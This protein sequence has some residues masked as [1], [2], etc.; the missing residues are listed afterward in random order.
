VRWPVTNVGDQAIRIVNAMQPHGQFRSAEMNIG[1]DL[2]VG[3]A[4]ELAL[5]VAFTASPG[6]LV[7]NP[8]LILLLREQD[9]EWRLLSRVRVRAGQRGEPIADGQ[10][11]STT[12]RVGA[13]E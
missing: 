3:A 6:D 12:Q 2:G 7:E 13:G 5:P 10:V 1:R 8:F 9:S 11:V 4:I